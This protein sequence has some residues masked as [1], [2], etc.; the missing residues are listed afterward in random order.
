MSLTNHILAERGKKNLLYK[1]KHCL[2][3]AKWISFEVS[4]YFKALYLRCQGES[5]DTMSGFKEHSSLKMLRFKTGS[6]FSC[7]HIVSCKPTMFNPA[8]AYSENHSINDN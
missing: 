7:Q 8:I 4:L 3:Y 2:D 5:L 6:F 1:H